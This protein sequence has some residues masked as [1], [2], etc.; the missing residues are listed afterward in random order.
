LLLPLALTV[1]VG[2]S[3]VWVLGRS[4]ER[5]R[6]DP[7]R[8]PRS[9]PAIIRP[10]QEKIAAALLLVG[11]VAA[12]I[13][14]WLPGR[15]R[16]PQ[17]DEVTLVQPGTIGQIFHD[18]EGAAN[19]P[20]QRILVNQLAPEDAT[21]QWGRYLSFACALVALAL[22]FLVGQ[23]ASA[24]SVLGGALA[25]A[26]VA[27]NPAVVEH[28]TL[29]RSYALWL[30]VALWHVLAMMDLVEKDAPPRRAY[31]GAALSAALLP[32]L[33]Y[34][35]VPILALEAVA[36]LAF[37]RHRWRRL[38]VLAGAALLSLPLLALVLGDATQRLPGAWSDL[39]RAIALAL[40]A[41][42]QD[43]GL[44]VALWLVPAAV[45]A[46]ETPSSRRY[47][48]GGVFAV[49]GATAIVAPLAGL[50]PAAAL[51]SLPF[52][53]PLLVATVL[54]A[55]PRALRIATLVVITAS[56]VLGIRHS[57][58]SLREPS[59]RD[60]AARFAAQWS[61]WRPRVK[62]ETVYVHP[63]YQ[64]SAIHYQLARRSLS[65]LPRRDWC[66][67][68]AICFLHDGVRFFGVDALDQAR[69]GLV[70]AFTREPPPELTA[71]CSVVVSEP[72][73]HALDCPSSP[74]PEAP[75]R[76]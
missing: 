5:R 14:L 63:A 75:T 60:A 41:G 54:R 58:R 46:G 11:A 66:P 72:F 7:T 13:F 25:V 10:G 45:F 34:A 57:S 53:A 61:D 59:A 38:S 33:H 71:R 20:L 31:L 27:V 37:A 55:E 70:V 8:P 68:A 36:L 67:G 24:G 43:H 52:L 44:L 26:L 29:F 16:G 17:G 4:R 6:R 48:L 3:V 18:A 47:L 32:W 12:V 64:G 39:E 42:W 28:A 1:L 40:A 22:A 56:F 2:A 15:D 73:L 19:P 49:L 23:R 21:V 62:H 69:S 9:A 30:P 50:R 74:R 35:S 51:F 76:E 65:S